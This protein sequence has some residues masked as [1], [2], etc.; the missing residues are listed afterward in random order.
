MHPV[1]WERISNQETT[2]VSPHGCAWVGYQ[3]IY[4]VS[5]SALGMK[6]SLELRIKGHLYEI[7][8]V[9]DE[10]LGSGQGFPAAE[11]DYKKT[12]ESVADCAGAELVDAVANSVNDAIRTNGE[13]PANQS[14]R[15]DARM[16]L[17][18][19]DIVADK[20]LNRA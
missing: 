4:G 9:N 19:E 10:V 8:A 1:G 14:V 13:R 5:G 7:G 2:V 15:K 12:L 20:N 6:R 11:T 17:A 16:R 18:D 3:G